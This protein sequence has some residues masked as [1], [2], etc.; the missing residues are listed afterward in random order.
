MS[1]YKALPWAETPTM[2]E[3][4]A[5]KFIRKAKRNEKRCAPKKEVEKA[6]KIFCDIMKNSESLNP[7]F[8]KIINDNIL[9]LI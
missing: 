4:E 7:E 1:K 3:A 9:D 2:T 8:A 5:K 6:I